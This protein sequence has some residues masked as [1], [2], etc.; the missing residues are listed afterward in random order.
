MYKIFF[1]LSISS[2]LLL[3]QYSIL[4][5]F[6]V[7]SASYTMTVSDSSQ[8]AYSLYYPV[9]HESEVIVL[10]AHG[11][12]RDRS[13]MAGFA[14]HFSSWGIKTITINLLHSSIF[15]NN[16][17]LDALDINIVADQIGQGL[18]IIY[19][20]H[21]SGG[22]RSV[23]AASQNS[24]A[25]SVLGLDLVDDLYPGTDNEYYALSAVSNMMVPVWGMFGES[26]ACN[27]NNNGVNVFQY[28]VQGNAVIITEADHCDFELPTNLL[29]SLLC[30][31]E[32]FIFSD[33]DIEDVVLNLSTSFIIGMI[34]FS[35]LN[36]QLWE[37]G[38]NYYD[39]LVTVGALQQITTLDVNEKTLQPVFFNLYQNFPNPFNSTTT[40]KYELFKSGKVK[41]V[42]INSIG[43]D[44]RSI[45]NKY[46]H[47]GEYLIQW[48]GIDDQGIK[49]AAGIYFYKIILDGRMKTQ[50][51]I[52]LK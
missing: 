46:H 36:I 39:S 49:M 34:N 27:A 30:A 16:P 9:N 14:E 4:G 2:N 17:I 33:E 19:V 6:E 10:L 20:G 8:M 37:P 32:N 1:I 51:M 42:I 47:V 13:V 35:E 7:S 23:L 40:L 12:S 45:I 29:C 18:P 3:G 5:P 48:D 38:N 50:K 15:D 41:I 22:M 28:A 44:V 21:S 52:Y 25:I 26:S 43:E 24:N 31:Q 11:F